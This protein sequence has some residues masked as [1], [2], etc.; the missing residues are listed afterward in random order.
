MGQARGDKALVTFASGLWSPEMAERIDLE[1]SSAALRQ[2]ENFIIE[3]YGILQRRPGLQSVAYVKGSEPPLP[4][5]A[6]DLIGAVMAVAWASEGKVY[7][8]GSALYIGG[9]GPFVLI[10]LNADGTHD[11]TFNNVAYYYRVIG[12]RVRPTGE[13][14]VWTDENVALATEY[15]MQLTSVGASDSDNW[16]IALAGN[17]RDAALLADGSLIVVGDLETFSPAQQYAVKIDAAGDVV[18][19]FDPVLDAP[20]NAVAVMESGEVALGL[21][22]GSIN[23]EVDP[24]PVGTVDANGVFVRWMVSDTTHGTISRRGILATSDGGLLVTGFFGGDLQMGALV[25]YSAIGVVEFSATEASAMTEGTQW[26]MFA[27]MVELP[28]GYL[29][30]GYFLEQEFGGVAKY[31]MLALTLAGEV[32]SWPDID[33]PTLSEADTEVRDVV[34]DGS[35]VIIGGFFSMVGDQPRQHLAKLSNAG[36]LI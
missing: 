33:G 17:V 14:I 30:V 4:S 31:G 8:G 35:T 18:T 7:V 23:G 20:V 13:V 2:C 27:R 22:A 25:K 28:S 34:V 5:F 36:V 1:K 11:T 24:E 32:V 21:T 26:P 12:I 3:P 6:P 29:A 16:E 10:R 15:I 19:A 9:V